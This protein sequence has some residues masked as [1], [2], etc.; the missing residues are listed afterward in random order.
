MISLCISFL[1]RN[2]RWGITF[3]KSTPN[4]TMNTITY[5]HYN[6]K[7]PKGR[8]MNKTEWT[9]LDVDNY[10]ILYAARYGPTAIWSQLIFS[11]NSWTSYAANNFTGKASRYFPSGQFGINGTIIGPPLKDNYSFNN[12]YLGIVK[13]AKMGIHGDNIDEDS[14]PR[15]NCSREALNFTV[16]VLIFVGCLAIF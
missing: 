14:K 6:T 15:S 4:K 9:G 13:S 10:K 5:V 12:T 2:Y 7:P 1:L 11:N 8:C 16:K 3:Y